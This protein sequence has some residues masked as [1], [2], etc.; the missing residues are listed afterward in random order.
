MKIMKTS[1]LLLSALLLTAC[2]QGAG[3]EQLPPEPLVEPIDPTRDPVGAVKANDK[4][5]VLTQDLNKQRAAVKKLIRDTRA[6]S[7]EQCRVVGFGN[8]PCGGPAEY[9][10]FSVKNLDE[11]DV[12]AR[13]SEYN[14]AAQADNMRRGLMS[15]CDITPEPAVGFA[16][17]HCTISKSDIE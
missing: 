4:I 13:I 16:K 12:R 10:V 11:A 15:T 14:Y 2:Q 5:V 9:V 8:K 3:G 6:D 17:G 7:I 1:A